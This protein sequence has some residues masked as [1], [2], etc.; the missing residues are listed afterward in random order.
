MG[1]LETWRCGRCGYETCA[2]V[3]HLVP[4][5]LCDETRVRALVRWAGET[6]TA[7]ELFG[8]R[9]I[10][11]AFRDRG[12]AEVRETVRGLTSWELGEF[13]RPYALSEL[14]V[15]V[16]RHGLSLHLV[17]ESGPVN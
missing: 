7:R 8:L 12:I 5:D 4:P 11:P 17:M 1:D 16:Q 15:L 3:C 13:A 2:T 10:V 14:T 6:P 9:A